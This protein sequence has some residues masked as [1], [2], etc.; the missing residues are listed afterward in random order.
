M[1]TY[2]ILGMPDVSLLDRFYRAM[3]YSAERG[4]AIACRLSVI[5]Y[6]GWNILKITSRP[7]NLSYLLKLTQTSAI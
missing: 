6:I 4:I 2:L 1:N 7:N 3:H 5:T